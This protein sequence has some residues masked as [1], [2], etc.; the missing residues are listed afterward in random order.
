LARPGIA[1]PVAAG[2]GCGAVPPLPEQ[3]EVPDAWLAHL[4]LC[5][6][7]STYAVAD[8]T[9]LDRQRVG[10]RLR[11]AG[12]S[13]RPRGAGG[14]R[15]ERRTGDPANLPEILADL[16]GRGGLN[17]IEVAAVLGMPDRTVRDRL[18]RYGI[19]VRTKGGWCREDRRVLPADL[20][21]MLYSVD[22]F[23][24]EEIGTKLDTSRKAVL[25]AAHDLGMPVRVG[26]AVLLPGPDEIELIGALYAD[27]RV[28]AVLATHKIAAVPPGG[29]I[30][31]RFPEPV[32]LTARLAGDLYWGCGVGLNHIEL[33]TGQPA[34]TVRGL[35]HRSGIAL[36]HPGGRSPFMRR[37]RTNASDQAGGN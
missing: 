25:R 7:L 13:L 21:W 19:P 31:Q 23:T 2:C 6:G 9:G 24:A 33:I 36:R 35:M 4:Y 30:W 8:L 37:W 3:D 1:G 26:G 14:T 11:G 32:P 17:T 27:Q 28:A 5:A 12:V 18:H 29:P 10:R 22:G 15:P 20:L 16:Y 34:G